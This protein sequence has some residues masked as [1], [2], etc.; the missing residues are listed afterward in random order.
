MGS[1]KDYLVGRKIKF[2]WKRIHGKMYR[3]IILVDQ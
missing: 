1:K 3:A 2:G